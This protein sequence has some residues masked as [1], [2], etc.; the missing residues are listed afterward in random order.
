MIEVNAI[1]QSRLR[2]NRQLTGLYYGLLSGLFF[3]LA[4]WGYDAFQLAEASAAHWGIKLA[5]GTSLCLLICGF[6]GWL[7]A[8]LDKT[9]V[10]AIS[11]TLAGI[12]CGWI[13]SRVPF[14]GLTWVQHLLE[15][16]LAELNYPYPFSMDA[17]MV[18][19]YII[20]IICFLLA[21]TVE[22]ILLDAARGSRNMITHWLMLASAT[23]LM[24]LAGLVTLDYVNAPFSAP[25]TALD[26][27]I[28][29]RRE[30]GNR[31]MDAT[32][33]AQNRVRSLSQI[34]NLIERPYRIFIL[35]YDP[36]S[37]ESFKLLVDFQGTW[38]E[39]T[40]FVN[41]PNTCKPIQQPSSRQQASP[42][43]ATAPSP[44][45]TPF[46]QPTAQETGI[47][48]VTPTHSDVSLGALPGF[49][50][51]APRYDIDLQVDYT[52]LRF[53]GSS[54]VDYT[55]VE[56]VPL[57]DLYFRLLPNFHGSFGPGSLEVSKLL[58]NDQIVD[59]ELGSQDTV[60]Q[61]PL[62]TTLQ[63]GQHAKIGFEFTGE[64]PKDFGGEDFPYAYGIYN[65]SD[66]V[67][68]LSSWYPILAVYDEQGWN[69]D[70]PSVIGDSV[71]SDMAFYEVDISVPENIILAATGVETGK[72]TTDGVTRLHYESGPMRDFALVMSPDFQISSKVVDDT[73]INLYYLPDHT[74][75][76]NVAL[77]TAADSFRYY[78]RQFGEYPYG[79]LDV[80]DAPLKNALGV[81]FPGIIFI[82]SSG[83]EAPD[84]SAFQVTVAHEVAHQWWYNVIG[85]D[86]FDDPWMDEA[87]TT[88]SSGLALEANRGRGFYEGLSEYWKDRYQRLVASGEDDQ[89]TR[90]LEHFEALSNPRVYAGIVYSKGALFFDALRKE[91]GDDALLD[92]LHN[93]YL[94]YKF[95]IAS[96]ENLLDTIEAS[97]S[98]Q[99][100]D[101]YQEWLYSP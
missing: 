46:P 89:V 13:A 33:A 12:G 39:C 14:E 96:P 34:E 56:S 80:I 35:S 41:S 81:E 38:A 32:V 63:P 36:N 98:R 17:R 84:D 88:F 93:Y 99:L 90:P 29:F 69:L 82:G 95:Q 7:T 16:A 45:E 25:I 62:P 15:P 61:V 22:N 30:Y 97:A 54:T 43:A 71:F 64:I 70:L 40:V 28:Q 6:A 26:N 77:T 10:G 86:I 55:N 59:Y 49:L 42:I 50:T 65:L 83:F 52:N 2:K 8:R 48:E 9:A 87:L 60:I 75:G 94:K 31:P 11:W 76:A 44:T 1:D 18:I 51:D 24:V 47:T 74:Q 92:A 100:D 85:N 3:S 53:H 66:N 37:L 72:S 67:L 21:G 91:I 57:D 58:V 20:V 68:T 4:A 79:E 5:L 23:P 27:V 78:N 73:Q 101:I 19:V